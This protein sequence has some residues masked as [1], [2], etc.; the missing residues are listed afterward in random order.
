MRVG[1]YVDAYNVYYG[2]RG[3][4][5]RGTAGWRW[6]DVR[7]LATTLVAQRTDWPGATVERI[8]YCTARIDASTNASG[9]RDQD[10]YLKALSASGSVDHIEYGKYA[11]R[12][13]QAPLAIKDQRGRPQLVAPQ[14]P[15]VVQSGGV[16]C[17]NAVFMVSYANREEK[18][19][20]VNVASHLLLDIL[21]GAV[22][23]AIVI[24]NDS[25]LSFPLREARNRVPVGLINPSRNHL[26]G[27]L[28]G[29]PSDGVGRHWWRPLTPTDFTSHQLSD[30]VQK[31]ARP[32]DW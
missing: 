6:L 29:A 16:P 12:V 14:W 30:P 2:G 10:I 32:Q 3:M 19:S 31:Y 22:D 5:G 23:A 24:S 28:R 8:I 25:D 27:D 1:V 26:A 15:I 9:H 21:T 13:K 17:T 11:Y 7:G 20:D 18:G 4:C